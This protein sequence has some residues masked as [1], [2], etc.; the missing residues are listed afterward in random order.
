MLQIATL[1]TSV[2]FVPSIVATIAIYA[3]LASATRLPF[4]LTWPQA[5]LVF[6]ASLV[7]SMA[8]SL[9][10]IRKL[11]TSNPLDLFS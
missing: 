8:A 5:L 4:A 6:A 2:A 7:M 3:A 11:R 9:L 1:I 10:A